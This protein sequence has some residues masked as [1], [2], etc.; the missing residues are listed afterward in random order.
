MLAYELF[1]NNKDSSTPDVKEQLPIKKIFYKNNAVDSKTLDEYGSEIIKTAE[2]LQTC[3]QMPLSTIDPKLL[4][5]P[6]FGRGANSKKPYIKI[7]GIL[8]TDTSKLILEIGKASNSIKHVLDLTTGEIHNNP[9]KK[10]KLNLD[11][12]QYLINSYPLFDEYVKFGIIDND[13]VLNLKVYDDIIK[14][15]FEFAKNHKP[16]I[17]KPGTIRFEIYVLPDDSTIEFRENEKNKKNDSIQNSFIDYFGNKS[18][19]YPSKTT[20][21]AKFLTFDDEALTVNCMKDADF[22]KNL[23]IGDGS[24]KKIFTNKSQTFTISQLKWI[25]V[26][27]FDIHSKFHETKKGILTQ[28]YENYNI[29]KDKSVSILVGSKVICIQS[30]KSQQ[31]LLINEN[32]TMNKMKKMFSNIKYTKDIPEFC[33]E[34][35]ID[36]SNKNTIWNTYLYVVR[37]FIGGRRT[38][39][40]YLLSYFNKILRQKIHDWAKDYVKKQLSKDYIKEQSSFFTKSD[41]CLKYLCSSNNDMKYMDKNEEFAEKIGKIANVYIKFKKKEKENNN[42]LSDILTYSK[43]DRERLRFILSRVGRGL[44]LSNLSDDEKDSTENQI[45]SLQSNEEI[46]DDAASKDYSYFFYKGFYTN[47]RQTTS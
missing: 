45:R 43:Y 32:L 17:T 36:T 4:N 46:E 7:R 14:I 10:I 18:S 30:K 11:K 20:Q 2:L 38:P 8:K 24:F 29:M 12:I 34:I 6:D 40:N 5:L 3:F 47:V 16:E 33:F 42:S 25:F 39:K 9:D 31:V 26:D 44:Q 35:L 41:F 23:G 21:T 13:G 22:Y 28:L 37:N 15:F 27:M 19:K 1:L